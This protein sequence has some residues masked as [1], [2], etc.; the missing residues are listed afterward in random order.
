LWFSYIRRFSI[1]F[2]VSLFAIRASVEPFTGFQNMAR[3]LQR[4][5]LHFKMGSFTVDQIHFKM[6]CKLKY[7]YL[8]VTV[9][10]QP[11]AATTSSPC[12]SPSPEAAI[13][14][15]SGCQGGWRQGSSLPSRQW[16]LGRRGIHRGGGL[17]WTVALW[18]GL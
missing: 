7:L 15:P 4:T 3:Q 11:L 13:G 12:S 8:M 1:S 16:R 9:T 10:S 6:G 17:S 14:Q 2:I 18:S 5:P